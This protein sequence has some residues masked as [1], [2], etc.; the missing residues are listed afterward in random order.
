MASKSYTVRGDIAGLP[1]VLICHHRDSRDVA[2]ICQ[3]LG[4][5]PLFS[6]TETDKTNAL[7]GI[8]DEDWPELMKSPAERWA[9]FVESQPSPNGNLTKIDA[10]AVSAAIKLGGNT[11]AAVRV[12]GQKQIIHVGKPFELSSESNLRTHCRQITDAMERCISSAEDDNIAMAFLRWG[13]RAGWSSPLFAEPD[14]MLFSYRRVCRSACAIGEI[15]AANHDGG[16]VGVMLPS[17]V[18]A[19]I[20]FYAAAFYG[21]T[22]VFLNP[23]AGR[24]SL[25]S[26]CE[27]ADIRTV[28]T[29]QKL[30]RVS[31]A[32]KTA[33]EHLKENGVKVVCLEDLRK[34]ITFPVTF[35]AVV[36]FLTPS[37]IVSNLPGAKLTKESEA[38]VLMTSGSESA[39]KG[40]ALGHGNLLANVTQTLA[41]LDGMRGGK[42]VNSLPVF[43]SFGLL[44]GVVLPAAGGITALQ[45]PTP[46][47]YREIPEVIRRFRP[48][49]FFSAD[50]FLSA[51][52]R[53]A[54][55]LDMSS[56]RYVFAG[57]EKLKESTR[58]LWA[59]KF[60]VRILQGY[61]VTETSPV[62]AVNSPAENRPDSVGRPVAG[63]DIRITPH[64]DI[65][66]GGVLSVRGENV[67][68]GYLRAN[69]P[70][71]PPPDGW[72]DTGDIV[73]ADK[74]GFL[75]I[76]GR[77]KRFAK[78]AGEMVP[79]DGVEEVLNTAFY[80]SQFA[81]VC[82]SEAKRGESV[83]VLCDN[84]DI[85]REQI[86]AAF[87]K[88]GHPS[89]WIPR[90]ILA[91]EDI[92][93][94]PAGKTDYPAVQAKMEATTQK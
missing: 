29:S 73:E 84:A 49:I 7:Y 80:P 1:R 58:R 25:D 3:L 15:I 53:E 23:A 59:E 70:I 27:I 36:A 79:L 65:K 28:Y 10:A 61:G 93:R 43:H 50:S 19:A 33:A 17:S 81:A 9:V 64:E 46:L 90:H 86:T 75:Y 18:G 52:A 4:C 74:D 6:G 56:L 35:R 34:Q 20:V 14:G 60:G 71:S 91:E 82:V 77:A 13:A 78:V 30:L 26:A 85:T 67:M 12:S 2:A 31:S 37:L 24:G 83:A 44:A 63:M 87:Q 62:I 5:R 40:V 68:L 51:Y 57:A 41:R 16:R 32:A 69:E 38:A 54:H 47:H 88:A 48:S 21:L 8:K 42:M 45:Y 39:P 55:P 92:P 11:F 94:L 66:R 76:V 89:L 72:Y 22:P